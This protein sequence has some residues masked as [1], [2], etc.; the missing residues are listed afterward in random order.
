MRASV[1]RGNGSSWGRAQQKTRASRAGQKRV[2]CHQSHRGKLLI[3]NANSEGAGRE[4]RRDNR[5]VLSWGRHA[6]LPKV[7]ILSTL[8]FTAYLYYYI[9]GVY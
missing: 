7:A 8:F 2:K 3:N 6:K 5:A 1:A 9:C 4:M